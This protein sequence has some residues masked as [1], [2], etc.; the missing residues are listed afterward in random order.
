MKAVVKNVREDGKLDIA[1]LHEGYDKIDP[2]GEELLELLKENDGFLD[3]SDKSDPEE[4]FQK[5]GWSKKVFKQVIGNLYK[6]RL[7]LISENGITLNLENNA[8]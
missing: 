3:L 7:I 1:L 4:V 2:L 5:T 8:D 6:K